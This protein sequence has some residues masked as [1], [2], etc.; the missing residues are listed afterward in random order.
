MQRKIAKGLS[1]RMLVILVPGF[2]FRIW[3]T[4]ASQDI[5]ADISTGL[6]V[7][8]IHDFAVSSAII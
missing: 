3:Q 8:A 4:A 6:L 7:R 5:Q 2:A 1:P